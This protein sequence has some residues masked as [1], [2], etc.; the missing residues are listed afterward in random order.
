MWQKLLR[1]P[2]ASA[3]R[4]PTNSRI[5]SPLAE[6]KESRGSQTK[7]FARDLQ[8]SP[9]QCLQ[10]T[11]DWTAK[12]KPGLQKFSSA[13]ERSRLLE[14]TSEAAVS[15]QLLFCQAGL[16]TPE[17]GDGI[18]INLSDDSDIEILEGACPLSD[19][20]NDLSEGA[21]DLSDGA[22]DDAAQSCSESEPECESQIEMQ[23]NQ[24]G[25]VF[26]RPAPLQPGRAAARSTAVHPESGRCAVASQQETGSRPVDE[27]SA[28][29]GAEYQQVS[30]RPGH[31]A[32]ALYSQVQVAQQRSAMP[33]P[34]GD[35][36]LGSGT[37]PWEGPGEDGFMDSGLGEETFDADWAWA[38][39]EI[40]A[41]TANVQES[42]PPS[43]SVAS[44]S[45]PESAPQC[46]RSSLSAT[47]PSASAIRPCGSGNARRPCTGVASELRPSQPSRGAC[48]SVAQAASGNTQ[49]Q[50]T[51][52]RYSCS[53]GTSVRRM[54]GASI[55]QWLQLSQSADHVPNKAAAAVAGSKPAAAE[56]AG[57]PLRS[58]GDVLGKRRRERTKISSAITFDSKKGRTARITDFMPAPA[59]VP[60]LGHSLLQAQAPGRRTEGSGGR[61]PPWQAV[62]GTPFVVD[63]FGKGTANVPC[64]HWF[65]SHFHAD[66]YG[67]LTRGFKQGLVHCTTITARLVHLRLKLPLDRLVVYE[68]NSPAVVDG[69]RVTFLEANH[70]PGAAIILF[71][72]P[73]RTPVLHTG[74]SRCR[75][76]MQQ[77]A[78]LQPLR[79]SLDLVLDTTYCDPQYTFPPQ[80]QVLQF[81]VDAVKA[82]AFNPRTLFLFG[83][84]TIGKEK[85]FLEVA[86]ALNKKVYVS[87]AK[88]QVLDCLGLPP[89]YTRLLTTN[90]TEADMHAVPLSMA[91]L[92][93]MARTQRHY[94][95]RFTTIV[96]FQP[97]GWSHTSGKAR[98]GGGKRRQKGTLIS[99]QVPYSEHSS[100]PE[101]QEFVHWLQPRRLIPSVGNDCGPKA[102]RMVEQLRQAPDDPK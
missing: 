93:A 97:T 14:T 55:P 18:E 36:Q 98:T 88:R 99:Y 31:Q 49:R 12:G 89:A 29:L 56:A 47:T 6:G 15:L 92:K 61:L 22:S 2:E 79:G 24:A 53:Q 28:A 81:V 66:H 44:T 1:G 76:E 64:Q 71:E 80:Q 100:F 72:P 86:R 5:S 58:I 54:Q 11:E 74:D 40:S 10:A 17:P 37:G 90:D 67:G 43:S 94:R 27:T 77:E 4:A 52:L 48:Q 7:G 69:I 32:G 75:K 35:G 78:C 83:T 87:R 57:K 39:G 20:A 91:S 63:K 30:G 73:G 70:C 101:L 82:E 33:Q 84:Y 68:L 62:P 38:A 8:N 26:C 59:P 21:N 65:L 41:S 102:R 13:T 19:G 46:T 42:A 96:G 50:R 45:A 25:T 85:L 34:V 60:S 3:K 95:S 51:E 16:A 9:A 23:T